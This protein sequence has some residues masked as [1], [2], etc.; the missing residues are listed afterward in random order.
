[1]SWLAIK[2]GLKKAWLWCRH[3]WKIVM[4]AAYTVILYML[5]SKNAKNA[6][7]ILSLQRETHKAEVDVLRDTH[8]KELQKR[9][10]NLKKYNDTLKAIE[11]K[12]SEENKKL[13]AAKK[14]RIKEIV[15][16]HGEDPQKL[17]EL[18]SDTFGIEVYTGD[19]NE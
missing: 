9:D 7:E 4:L 5:F 10:E 18:V 3:N 2:Y 14:K 16:E 19:E 11:K 8:T 12:Y 13:T 17:A 6:K 15:E 1:M